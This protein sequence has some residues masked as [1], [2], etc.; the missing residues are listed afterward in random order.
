MSFVEF[1]E[2][3]SRMA[4]KKSK[5]P[6]GENQEDYNEEDLKEL[7][8]S[9]KIESMLEEM[10]TKY[11]IMHI[12]KKTLFNSLNSPASRTSTS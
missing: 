5:V 9:Y 4:E 7:H 12:N 11:E 10:Q 2:A 6:I 8:L 1:L 3:L